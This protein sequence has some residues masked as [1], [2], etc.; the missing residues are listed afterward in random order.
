MESYTRTSHKSYPSNLRVLRVGYCAKDV[1]KSG[2]ENS[3]SMMAVMRGCMST[4]V[5]IVF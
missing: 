3:E 5:I 4:L 1:A 2:P